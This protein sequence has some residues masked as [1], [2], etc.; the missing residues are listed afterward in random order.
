[1]NLAQRKQ[2]GPCLDIP[3]GLTNFLERSSPVVKTLLKKSFQSS[4]ACKV[5]I[6]LIVSK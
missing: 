5:H 6:S 2:T 4:F 1:M 3:A